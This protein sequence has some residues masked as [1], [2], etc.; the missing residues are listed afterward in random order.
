MQFS[1]K[2]S[3]FIVIYVL[4]R[5]HEVLVNNVYMNDSLIYL[6]IRLS[7]AQSQND[8][9][10]GGFNI[11]FE[12]SWFWHSTTPGHSLIVES[13]SYSHL[14]KHQITISWHNSTGLYPID[15]VV[16]QVRFDGIIVWGVCA[17]Y[18]HWAPGGRY[19]SLI[20]VLTYGLCKPQYIGLFTGLVS[21]C[22]FLSKV[23]SEKVSWRGYKLILC[24]WA[25]DG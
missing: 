3:L 15:L 20:E 4:Y 22:V 6:R 10:I 25:P 1:L 19:R 14:I 5:N 8:S 16:P 11:S 2:I 24:H 23:G 17:Y 13:G 9:F 7:L 21:Q 12:F 18:F